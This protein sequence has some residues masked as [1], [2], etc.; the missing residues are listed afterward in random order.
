M[1]RV[2]YRLAQPIALDITLE[3]IGFTVL[4]GSSG[5]GKTTL[6]KAVA[7][8]LPGAGTPFGGLP[9]EYRPVGY[10]PQGYALFPHLTVWRNVAYAIRGTR[11]AKYARACELLTRVGLAELAERDPRTLSG[12]QMQRVALARALARQ[13]ELLLLD[14]PTNALDPATRDRVLEELRNLINQLAVPALVATHDPHL[15][16]IGDRVAVLAEGTIVQQDVPAAVFDYP[17]TSRVAR[18]VGFQNLWHATALAPDA[19]AAV[20]T[21]RGVELHLVATSPPT[22]DVGIAIRARDVIVCPGE[23]PREA[24]NLL[25]TQI[26]ELRPEGLAK[27][28]VLNGPLPLEVTVDSRRNLGELHAGDHLWVR[29]PPERLRVFRWDDD[30]AT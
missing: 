11:A 28:L 7:G 19:G 13:P 14:E 27:R 20:A 30:P 24:V 17:A 16:A 26:V 22:N 5:A 3:I 25:Q 6:L 9:P 1:M 12:G 15:A 21:V 29:L 18:L 4:L 10:M 2:N 8:L 23:R